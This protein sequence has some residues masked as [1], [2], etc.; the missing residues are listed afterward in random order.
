[1]TSTQYINLGSLSI[2]S[3]QKIISIALA[4]AALFGFNVT[5]EYVTKNLV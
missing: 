5:L 1:M 2:I 4:M 3:F